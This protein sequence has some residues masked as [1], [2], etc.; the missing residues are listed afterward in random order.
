[1]DGSFAGTVDEFDSPF[2]RLNLAA[3]PH[4]LEVRANGYQTLT[5]DV[6][7]EPRVTISYSAQLQAA[8]PG[9]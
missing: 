7:I 3:G 6:K 5:F 8:Q 4:R 9:R 2:Q 1:M